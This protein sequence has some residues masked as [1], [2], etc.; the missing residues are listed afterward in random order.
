M[1]TWFI[2]GA[3]AL[4]FW[5]MAGLP[6][7]APQAN[8]EEKT[9]GSNAEA[10][11]AAPSDTLQRLQLVNYL[12]QF[13]RDHQ[14]FVSLVTAANILNGVRWTEADLKAEDRALAG[15]KGGGD[16]NAGKS[17]GA[18]LTSEALVAEAKT[19]AGKDKDKLALIDKMVAEAQSAGGQMVMGAR[20]GAKWA[21]KCLGSQSLTEYEVDFVGGAPAEVT[22]DGDGDT[23]LDLYV[24]DEYG[25]LI[26]SDTDSTD[27]CIASW[28]PKWTG[29]FTVRI[30]NH[31]GIANCYVL[32]TN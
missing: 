31:G 26:D 16:S 7:L 10:A 8:A 15:A 27:Y 1:R 29:S 12:V 23:D 4:A 5:S 17:A 32:T 11:S 2:V 24:Y 30:V 13:G 14:D 25:N 6:S 19:M 18:P 20:G 22:V 9:K 21:S 28:T 3:V